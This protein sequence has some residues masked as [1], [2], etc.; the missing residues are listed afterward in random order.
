MNARTIVLDRN[1]ETP[2]YIAARDLLDQGQERGTFN[3]LDLG[4]LH[5]TIAGIHR[6]LDPIDIDRPLGQGVFRYVD[7]KTAGY[8]F[9]DP[10]G[11]LE[12]PM[13]FTRTG[14]GQMARRVLGAGGAK[15]IDNLKSTSETGRKLAEVNWNFGLQGETSPALLRTVKLP[16]QTFRTIRASLSGGGRGY[17]KIDNIDIVTM[18]L[19]S[20]EFRDLPV[21][22]AKVGLDSMRL[23]MLLDPNDAALFDPSTGR[24]MNPTGSHDTRLRIPVPMLQVGN[25]EVGNASFSLSWGTYTYGCLNGMLVSGGGGDGASYRWNHVGGDDRAD[26]IKAGFAD[27]LRSARVAASGAVEQ[28]KAST[29]VAVED[30][31][32][33]LDAWA[34][35]DLTGNQIERVKDAFQDETVTPGKRLASIIDAVTLA[36]QREGDLTKQGQME[37]FAHRLL[38]KGLAIARRNDGRIALPAA[39]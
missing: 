10:E 5:K 20:P 33:T 30:A 6:D 24:L 2:A 26:R 3:A 19:D 9:R 16:G 28:Y 13:N 37:R 18:L 25:G 38:Q 35:N 29:D 31:F 11:H 17:A 12:T 23:R 7:G 27:A 4:N 34:G 32:A 36:A 39:A 15:Y 21:I 22:D 1:A 8:S 14:L